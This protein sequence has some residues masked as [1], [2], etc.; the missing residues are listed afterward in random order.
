MWAHVFEAYLTGLALFLIPLLLVV[1]LA[2]ALGLLDRVS[3]F[4]RARK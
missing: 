4:F 1:A 3:H 2:G